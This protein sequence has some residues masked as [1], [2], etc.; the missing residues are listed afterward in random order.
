MLVLSVRISPIKTEDRKEVKSMMFDDQRA[1]MMAEQRQR[2]AE[3]A[4]HEYQRK[5][6]IERNSQSPDDEEEEGQTS[7]A[8][9]RRPW[10]RFW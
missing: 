2:E 8:K 10:W 6:E 4:Q 1:R 3:M 5:S 9:K 7:K